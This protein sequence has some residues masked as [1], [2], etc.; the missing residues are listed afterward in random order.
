VA[1]PA[2]RIDVRID[3][4]GR[5]VVPSSI[6]RALSLLPN[7]PLVAHVEEGRLVIEKRETVLARV[8]ARFSKVPKGVDLAEELIGDRRKEAERE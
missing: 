2:E 3:R 8:K 7:Q 6:R 5:V 1:K 4:Q